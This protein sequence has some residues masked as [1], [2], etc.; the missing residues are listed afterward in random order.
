MYSHK[1]GIDEIGEKKY[2][3]AMEDKKMKKKVF[4]RKL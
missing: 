2:I 4:C 1:D 3:T